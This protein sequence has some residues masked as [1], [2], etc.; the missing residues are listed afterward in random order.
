MTNFKVASVDGYGDRDDIALERDR[1]WENR[2]PNGYTRW[3]DYHADEALKL[4]S[5]TYGTASTAR[6]IAQIVEEMIKGECYSKLILCS[7]VIW[8][9]DEY[10]IHDAVD[11]ACIQ[12]GLDSEE[13]SASI[14]DQG[15]EIEIR[16]I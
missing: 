3:E 12:L 15:H 1:Q 2:P 5:T 14:H 10:T 13:F 8:P 9:D 6:P 4:N 11:E 16:L 7:D